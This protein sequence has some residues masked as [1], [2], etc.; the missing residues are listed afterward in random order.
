MTAKAKETTVLTTPPSIQNGF[1]L[2]SNEKLLELY[3][4]MRKC[5]IIHERV[6][7]LIS[8]HQNGPKVGNLTAQAAAWSQ[9]AASVGMTID[10]LP[11][12]SILSHPGDFIPAFIRG[13]ELTVLFRALFE[14]VAPQSGR[15][16]LKIATDKAKLNKRMRNKGIV[17]AFSST[18]DQLE[19]W[20]QALARAGV[21][22]LPMVF[23]SWNH[24][25]TKTRSHAVPA[26]TVDGN[27][28]VAVYRVAC[29]AISH[30]RMGNGPTLIECQTVAEDR[31]DPILNMESYLI[32][33]GIFSEEFKA[34]ELARFAKELEAAV[35]SFKG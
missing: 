21:Q 12:D 3:T 13:M 32:R 16:R 18:H 5:R 4:T 28:V 10:L 19:P 6:R 11:E 8:Q 1:S 33:K 31:G 9:E 20:L 2:I 35:K 27:D 7:I 15:A 29:E 25:S 26:I 30:A 14:P 17:V 34:T 23:L 22:D 24:N